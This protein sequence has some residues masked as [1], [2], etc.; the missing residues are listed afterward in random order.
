MGDWALPA[1]AL[2]TIRGVGT[3][4]K[5]LPGVLDVRTKSRAR[6]RR[7]RAGLGVMRIA[8]GAWWIAMSPWALVRAQGLFINEIIAENPD[9]I[10]V[11]DLIYEHQQFILRT[12]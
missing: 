9:R 4:D 10:E 6:V 7:S 3:A 12:I 5:V 8:F 1:R 2:V 11:V